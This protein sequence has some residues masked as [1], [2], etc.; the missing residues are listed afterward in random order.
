M[1]KIKGFLISE[2][3]K[4][5]L[6][7]IIVILVGLGS[8]E[9]GRLSKQNESSG[10]RIEYPPALEASAIKAASPSGEGNTAPAP[11]SDSS[12]KKFFA[13]SRGSKYYPVTCSAGKTI[14][15]ENRVYFATKAEAEKAGYEL[16]GSCR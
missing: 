10:I 11:A 15:I 6:T 4:D 8:F 13:S 16:S 5:V 2:T 9:L 7:V 14:K 12:S 1:E 3:G